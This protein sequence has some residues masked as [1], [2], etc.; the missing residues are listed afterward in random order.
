MPAPVDTSHRGLTISRFNSDMPP[1]DLSWKRKI[2]A[3]LSQLRRGFASTRKTRF[4]PTSMVQDIFIHEGFRGFGVKF[5]LT[6]VVKGEEDVVVVFPETLPNRKVL[7]TV[8]RGARGCLFGSE[9]SDGETNGKEATNQE[10]K[11]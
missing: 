6:V 2:H 10:A 1:A 4:I 7:E 11:A 5:Y 3:F 9:N 8:W